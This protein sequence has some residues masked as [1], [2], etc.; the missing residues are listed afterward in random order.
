MP[1]VLSVAEEADKTLKRKADEIA[2]SEDNED[3]V[4]SGDDLEVPDGFLVAS[5]E[6][7]LEYPG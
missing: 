7:E 3:E 2:D 1:S 4:G 5:S 6:P